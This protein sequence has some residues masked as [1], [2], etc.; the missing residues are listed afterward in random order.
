MYVTQIT[1][2]SQQFVG[3]VVLL[4]RMP[5]HLKLSRQENIDTGKCLMILAQREGLFGIVGRPGKVPQAPLFLGSTAI[6]W[7][8]LSLLL[9]ATNPT[10]RVKGRQPSCVVPALSGSIG[11]GKVS[12]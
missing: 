3:S 2:H 6:N 10:R 11:P 5:Q 8:E 12:R 7:R 1:R 4:E 9:L